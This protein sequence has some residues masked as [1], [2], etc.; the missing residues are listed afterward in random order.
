MSGAESRRE[1]DKGA[2]WF[3]GLPTDERWQLGDDLVHGCVE[4]VDWGF[5]KRPS[6]SFV[7]GVDEAR[8]NWES[9]GE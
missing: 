5:E 7:N 1:R 9:E 3:E 8:L 6:G 4:W 2:R